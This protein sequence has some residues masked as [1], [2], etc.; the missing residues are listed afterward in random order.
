MRAA[1][2]GLLALA[3]AWATAAAAA[4]PLA[5][6]E[7]AAG[8]FV[9]QG[10]HEDFTPAN[11]GGIANLGF[12]V[13]ER[14]VA[15]IDSGGSLRQGEA[16]LAAIRARTDLPVRYVVATHVHPDHLFGHAAFRDGEAIFVGHANL[17]QRLAEN[18]P[19]YLAS[20]RRLVGEA[21][22]GTEPVAPTMQVADRVAIDLG[23]RT[24]ELR[25]WP[26][27]HTDTDLTVLDSATGTL[28]AGDL[29]FIE[30]LP[31]VDGNLLGW[32]KVMD[33]LA[34]IP[35]QRVVPGHG[36][37]AAPWPSALAPQRA[38]LEFLRDR[39]R[40]ELRRNRTLE[41]AVD[42][43]PLPPGQTWLLAA[44]NH[45]RNVTTSFTELEWE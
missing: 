43:V 26:A 16:L 8:V 10:P 45:P 31:V 6:V 41:Q 3:L 17:A 9:H 23:G 37:P 34:A 21:F 40:D 20:L 42:E 18:A 39:V 11:R 30:R 7:V 32:L 36:P 35:A 33:R 2:A 14:A 24:L 38:Y 29:L 13:G 27:A 12:V 1:A 4:A 28:F 19:Y 44:E 5:V 25:A 22:A 15:V